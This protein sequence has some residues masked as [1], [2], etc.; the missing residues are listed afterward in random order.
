MVPPPPV[1]RS[2]KKLGKYEFSMDQKIGSGMAGEV[3]V[4]FNT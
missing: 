3:F 1:N 2:V 4:G